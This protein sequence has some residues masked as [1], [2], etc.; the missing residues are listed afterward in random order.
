MTP[1]RLKSVPPP[2]TSRPWWQGWPPAVFMLVLVGGLIYA[3]ISA[4]WLDAAVIELNG[5]VATQ[6]TAL[7]EG[8][9]ERARLQAEI[10]RLLHIVPTE[11]IVMEACRPPHL[12]GKRVTPVFGRESQFSGVDR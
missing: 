9:T 11:R 2:P 4:R 5:K 3:S 8:S 1:R 10:D 7:E 6:A 12:D